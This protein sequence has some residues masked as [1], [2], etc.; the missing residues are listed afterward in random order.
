MV[1]DLTIVRRPGAPTPAA[2]AF[3]AVAAR[4]ATRPVR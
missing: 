4:L 2:A 3:L 1:R